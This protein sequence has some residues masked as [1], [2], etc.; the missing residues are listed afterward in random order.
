MTQRTAFELL[1]VGADAPGFAAAA[2]AARSGATAAVAATGGETPAAGS[3]VEPPNFVWRLLDL[4]A[5][6]LPIENA[7]AMTTLAEKAAL[8]T[9]GDPVRT[10]GAL[11]ERDPELEHL[12]PAFA[13][14]MKR[15]ADEIAANEMRA[16]PDLF[17]SAN[18]ALDDYFADEQLKAHLISSFAAPFG[19]A[20]DEAGSAGAL[21]FA[22]A[23]AQRRVPARALNDALTLAAQAAGVETL[24]GVL[25]ALVR[26][27]GKNWKAVMDNGRE[28]RARRVMASSALI[29]EAAGLRISCNGS[30]LVRRKGAQA[31]I[32]IRY[33]KRPTAAA[34]REPGVFFTAKDRSE[35]VR[36]RNAMIEGR[37]DDDPVLSFE[38][39]GKEIIA[40][41]PFCPSR[42]RENGEEREWTGQDRQILGR[43]AATLIDRTLGGAV[44]TIR[45]IDVTIGP[46]V[47]SGLKRR[48]FETPA[49]PAPAPSIDAV[50]AAA[51]LGMEIVR[52][53]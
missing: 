32:K 24:A 40:R 2:C 50:G 29:G 10:G 33:D 26:V 30:P 43:Q 1:V 13:A 22:G 37:L 5:Y 39:S 14:D 20:G 12:W 28:L 11:A 47:A 27:D 36:A 45:E 7:G 18:A 21:S 16:G 15:R 49:I 42:L 25:Q 3:V 6:E 44:G 4:H 8:S 35:I 51:A 34:A 53:D 17:L 52:H 31:Q 38:I 23:N 41:A 9:Y 46:D 19:L 48:S